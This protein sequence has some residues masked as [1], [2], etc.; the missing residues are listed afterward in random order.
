MALTFRTGS[1]GKGSA[2]TIEELDNNFRH[3]TGS[4]TVNGSLT[5]SGSILISGSIIPSEE[6]AT[7]GTSDNPWLEVFA[8]SDSFKLVSGSGASTATAS[9][10]FNNGVIDFTSPSGSSS[11][12]SLSGSFTGSISATGSL[13]GSFTG[14]ISATGSV[15][16]SFTGSFDTQFNS[17]SCLIG[18]T[19]STTPTGVRQEGTFEFVASASVYT[20]FVYLDGAWRSSS[21]S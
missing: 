14:S 6:S 10:S 4:H 16:G 7:L 12:G 2:L 18:C 3:F 9:I 8:S 20:M 13:S 5:V 1:G 11:T 17:G 19:S 15:S 21:L